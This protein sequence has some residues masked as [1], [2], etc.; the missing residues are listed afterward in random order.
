MCMTFKKQAFLPEFTSL[1]VLQNK[2]SF[3][4]IG[5]RIS[6]LKNKLRI[7]GFSSEN[8]VKLNG[9]TCTGSVEQVLQTKLLSFFIKDTFC[10][11]AGLVSTKQIALSLKFKVKPQVCTRSQCCFPSFIASSSRAQRAFFRDQGSLGYTETNSDIATIYKNAVVC[12][13]RGLYLSS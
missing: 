6:Y 8:S 10:P 1:K 13:A 3:F 4:P 9:N 5:N 7:V 12:S 11:N 2:M